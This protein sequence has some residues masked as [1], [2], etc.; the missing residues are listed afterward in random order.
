MSNY[1][2]PF[3]S[4]YPRRASATDRWTPRVDVHETE[5]GYVF[6]AEVP[7][8]DPNDVDVTVEKNVLTIKGSKSALEPDAAAGYASLE[9]ASGSFERR[10]RM[11]DVV[12]SD[13]VTAKAHH[14]V[15]E[16]TVAK[17]EAHQPQRIAI[18]S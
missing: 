16:I 2:T 13:R 4:F 14:G 8:V 12:D 10:F 3:P 18:A 7:G 6:T 5:S 17:A 9:R 1:L 11:P 15:I